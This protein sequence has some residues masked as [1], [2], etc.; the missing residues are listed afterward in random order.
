MGTQSSA[1]H[2]RCDWCGDDPLYQK[3]HDEEWGVTTFDERQL[4]EQ[5]IL[6]GAQAG[7]SWLTILRKRDHYRRAFAQFD[8]EKIACYDEKKIQQLMADSGIIRHHK[9]ILATINNAQRYLDLREEGA[10]LARYLWSFLEG[11]KIQNHWR[12]TEQ[13]PRQTPLSATV[14]H[15]LR[16]RGFQFIGPTIVYAYMQAIG[17][18]NDHT[19]D[20]HCH[21]PCQR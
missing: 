4:F 11:E 20:C 16:Q 8:A 15:D 3:Y 1:P 19:I 6:E 5:L 9:K 10:T 12:N 13:I 7:L 2:P 17:M 21:R 14:S 18:V